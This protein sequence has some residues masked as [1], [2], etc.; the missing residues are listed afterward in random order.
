LK[1]LILVFSL[2]A[3]PISVYAGAVGDFFN[4]LFGNPAAAETVSTK[5]IQNMAILAAVT[6]PLSQ[7]NDSPKVENDALVPAT[8]SGDTPGA[9]D[10]KPTSDQISTYVVREGDTLSQIAQMYDV[11]VNTIKWGNNL[12]SNTVKPGDTLVILP[13]TGVKVTVAKGDTISSLAKKYNA[14]ADEI[15]AYNNISKNSPLAVGSI[16]IV[17]DGEVSVSSPSYYSGGGG[18]SGLKIFEGFF[19]KPLASYIKTQGVH[20]NNAVDLADPVGTSIVA[21][22]SGQV[23]IARSG[24]WNGGYGNY[25]VIKHSNG[26][27]TLYA[28]ASKIDVVTGQE[29]EQGSVIGEV[30]ST[31]KSTGPHLH[32]EIRGAKN[33]F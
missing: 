4:S 30:G 2:L 15:A 22:A 27:Q 26:T 20:G 25:I 31:G 8:P 11:T 16:I 3:L 12:A 28:H 32:F 14:D 7:E 18:S 13:I 6:T 10:N 21:S 5:N 24:G 19:L 1:K 9:L 29:V 33:P 17:P 23:I